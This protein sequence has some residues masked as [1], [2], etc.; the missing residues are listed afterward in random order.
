MKLKQEHEFSWV[1]R[2]KIKIKTYVVF[3]MRLCFAGEE[4]ERDK[5]VS[6]NFPVHERA[7]TLG[8]TSKF[9]RETE[10]TRTAS[11]FALT[12]CDF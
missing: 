11:V 4:R 10:A 12:L 8:F 9:V 5:S 2:K 6:L 7:F 1:Q 3:F